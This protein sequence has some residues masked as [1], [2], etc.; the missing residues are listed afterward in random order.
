MLNALPPT[1][2]FVWSKLRST[3]I[4]PS[5]SCIQLSS[6]SSLIR[7]TRPLQLQH[8]D[9]SMRGLS[10]SI[11]MALGAW[12]PLMETTMWVPM[13]KQT[14]DIEF[15]S[16]EESPI[17]V[18]DLARQ[19]HFCNITCCMLWCWCLQIILNRF[20]QRKI[21]RSS[22]AT[23]ARKKPPSRN[24]SLRCIVRRTNSMRLLSWFLRQNWP[25]TIV[26]C[27]FYPGLS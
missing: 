9:I 17:D 10:E 6:S 19:A 16:L 7:P 18:L 23:N 12:W 24:Y 25:T 13:S 3:S 22:M 8:C 14:S 20:Q 5:S 4:R 21:S 11:L 27:Q 1:F 15:P 26:L 2:A